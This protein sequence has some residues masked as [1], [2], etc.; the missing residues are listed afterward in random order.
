VSK[1]IGIIIVSYNSGQ[2]LEVCIKAARISA[3]KAGLECLPVAVDNN[4]KDSSVEAAKKAKAIVIANKENRGFA[5]G[6]N[7]GIKKSLENGADYILILNPDVK[8]SPASIGIMVQALDI[9]DIGAAGPSL[10]DNRGKA[11]NVGY[12]FKAP[13]WLSVSLFSTFLRPYALRSKFLVNK[14]SEEGDMSHDREVEQIPG[15]CLL[16]SRKILEKVGLLDEDFAIWFEDVEWCYRARRLGYKMWFCSEAKVEHESGT[17]FERWQSLDK[18]VTFYVSMK[19]FFNKHKPLS[20][21][22]VRLAITIN[23]LV[24]FVKNRDKSN[25]IFLKKFW[26]QKRGILPS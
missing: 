4:S 20:G 16:T 9:N 26:T 1:K 23:S 22:L 10:I 25:L 12:Y 6:V 15:A 24:L 11:A 5:G 7:Q 14:F 2:E 18:A 21:I 19:T 3:E 8:L 17:S 13:S